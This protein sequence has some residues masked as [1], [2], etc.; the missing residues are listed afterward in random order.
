MNNIYD[1]IIIG[2]GPAGLS[3]GLYAGRA[4]LNTLIIEKKQ[5]G[6]QIITTSEVVNYPGIRKTSGPALMEEMHQQAKDFGV[7][8][9]SDEIKQVD[10]SGE[11]KRLISDKQEYFCRA[12]IIATGAQPRKIGFSGEE[13]FTGR[14]VAYCATCD[15][16][17]FT[18][19]DIFVIGGGYAAAEEAMFL[20]RY[21]KNVTMII[22]EPD[23]TCAKS[24]ADKVRSMDNITIHYNTEVKEL[25]GDD[26]LKQATFVNNQTGETFTY[27]ASEEDQTFGVFVFAGYEPSTALFKDHI[28]LDDYGYI[29]TDENLNTNVPGVIAAGDLRPKILRQIVTSV[30]DGA[31]AAI[32]A[33][34]YV[35]DEKERLGITDE[36]KP[37]SKPKETQKNLT[38]SVKQPSDEKQNNTAHP[39]WSDPLMEQVRGVLASLNKNVTLVTIVDSQNEKSVSLKDWLTVLPNL[40]SHIFLEVYE[41]GTN[42]DIET[43]IEA[44]LL[45]MVAFL[46]ESGTY[47]GVKFCG[48]PGGHE[49]NSFILA[50]YNLAG[51]GQALDEKALRQI[52]AIDKKV[53]LKIAISLSCTFCPDVVAACHRIAMLNPNIEATMMDLSLF[54]DIKNKFKIMSVPAIIKDDSKLLF[55]SKTIEEIVEFIQQ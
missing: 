5:V 42:P 48:I 6:G 52:Q 55:G 37:V 15:G 43:K 4:M 13:E 46:D 28:K 47:T 21:G 24:I 7:S 44:T 1:L 54:P 53:N 51:P 32:T 14:G 25:S 36:S 10:F 39:L 11:V 8:F 33:E 26:L 12:V 18:G 23:F 2:G 17:F 30:A 27:T 40:S 9:V 35:A 29:L 16:E 45:P 19:L 31:I 50:L 34:R 22:R 3:A 41:K 38:E 20:T 49:L